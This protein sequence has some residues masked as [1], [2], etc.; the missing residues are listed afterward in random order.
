MNKIFLG[1]ARHMDEIPSNSIDLVI[2]SPPYNVDIPYDNYNDNQPIHEFLNLLNDTWKECYRVLKTGGRICINVANTHRKPY[3]HLS[4]II[5]DQLVNLN[6]MLRGEIIWIKQI[7]A[8]ASSAWGSFNSP[9]NP[10]LRDYHEYI[11]IAH[12]EE[13]K[14]IERGKSDLIGSKFVKYTLG[15]WYFKPVNTHHKN[16]HP[17]PFPEELPRRCIQ[18]YS[19][20]GATILDPFCGSGTTCFV[21]KQLHRKYIGYDLS[22]TYVKQA[23]RRCSQTFLM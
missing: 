16:G 17:V 21:A 23:R 5:A 2:T 13:P 8:N 1:D 3:F 20:I 11:I 6:Y 19:W 14:L 22:P 4:G 7:P 9:S 12:K 15:E 10:A 18:L